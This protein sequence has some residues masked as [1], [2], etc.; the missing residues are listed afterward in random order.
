MTRRTTDQ[1]GRAYADLALQGILNRLQ[2]PVPLPTLLRMGSAL[3]SSLRQRDLLLFLDDPTLQAAIEEN[4][5]DGGLRRDT[6]DY[7]YV[8]D[9]NVGWS[10]SDRNVERFVDYQVDLRKEPRRRISLTLGYNNHSGPGSPGCEPQWLN[11]GTSYGQL[12]NACYWNFWRVYVPHGSRLLSSSPLPLPEYSVSAETGRGLPGG[13]TV[14]VSS[15]YESTVMS[16]LFAL[17]AGSS[18][19]V[20]LVY[21]LPSDGRPQDGTDIQYELLI[22]KQPGV[23]RRHVSVGFTLPPGYRLT[24]T[25]AVPSYDHGSSIGFLF[26]IEEDTRLVAVFTRSGDDPI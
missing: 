26:Q 24:S 21:D 5:W 23:R 16:G 4:D 10:K 9:S 3:F 1:H 7:V 15:S 14:G 22:Q 11:R 8:V 18:N 12:K 6:Q 13:D 17:E 25:S 2:E 19:E 20:S